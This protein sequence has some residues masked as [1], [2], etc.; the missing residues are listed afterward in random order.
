MELGADTDLKFVDIEVLGTSFSVA[1]ADIGPQ[2]GP[3]IVLVH[4]SPATYRTFRKMFH[5]LTESGFRM[6]M[7]NF[8]GMGYTEIDKKAI[9]NFSSAHKAEIVKAFIKAI[10]INSVETLVGFSSGGHVVARVVADKEFHPIVKSLT[11]LSVPGGKP[12]SLVR[13]VYLIKFLGNLFYRTL[14]IPIIGWLVTLLFMPVFRLVDLRAKTQKSKMYS[15][16][17]AAQLI[18]NSAKKITCP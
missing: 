13:P 12:Y 15:V 16:F 2:D 6:V 5:P 1:Y 4:G 11:F 17:E 3:V 18:L 9:Y 8:P 10:D 14:S 7:P